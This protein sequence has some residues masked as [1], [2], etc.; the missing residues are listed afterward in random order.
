MIAYLGIFILGSENF[1]SNINEWEDAKL[2]VDCT[3]MYFSQEEHIPL[4]LPVSI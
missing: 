2:N 3:K 4:P 1:D